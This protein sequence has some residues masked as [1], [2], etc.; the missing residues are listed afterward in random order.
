M[1]VNLQAFEVTFFI[2]TQQKNLNPKSILERILWPMLASQERSSHFPI[3][4]KARM[5]WYLA[6][7]PAFKLVKQVT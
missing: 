6:K 4:G 5:N 3:L 2:R 1:H 7:P